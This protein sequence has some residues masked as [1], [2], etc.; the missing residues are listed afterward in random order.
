MP[1]Q[2]P[3]DTL[4]S[5]DFTYVAKNQKDCV[6]KGMCVHTRH[7]NRR[8]EEKTAQDDQIVDLWTWNLHS[9][10]KENESSQQT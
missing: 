3:Y 7:K 2:T 9:P 6:W 4:T 5:L 10:L 1:L 8:I